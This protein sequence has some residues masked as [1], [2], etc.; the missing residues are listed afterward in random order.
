MA[1]TADFRTIRR[2]ARDEGPSGFGRGRF[3]PVAE[4]RT[5]RLAGHHTLLEAFDP[6]SGG[7][8]R[9][10]TGN[11]GRRRLGDFDFNRKIIFVSLENAKRRLRI[12]IF[13]IH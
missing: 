3:R 1:P 10:E 7:L 11:G 13:D 9:I 8:H 6:K 4:Q 12:T 5:A 2:D